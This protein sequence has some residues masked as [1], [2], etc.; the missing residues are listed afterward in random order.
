M[1]SNLRSWSKPLSKSETKKEY[2]KVKEGN[3]GTQASYQLSPDMGEY[4]IDQKIIE[5]KDGNDFVANYKLNDSYKLI[6]SENIK[7]SIKSNKEY[8]NPDVIFTKKIG[9]KS[10]NKFDIKKTMN[11]TENRAWF[12]ELY[13]ESV[14]G[15]KFKVILD[16]EEKKIIFDIEKLYNLDFQDYEFPKQIIYFGAPGTGKS[17]LLNKNAEPFKD[18]YRRITFHPNIMYSDLVGTFK[19]FPTQNSQTPITYEYIPGTLIKTLIDALTNPQ[20]PYLLII[21]EINRAN[22]S[23]AFGDMFQLLDRN[24][25][26]ESTYPIDV[27]EDLKLYL[28]KIKNNTKYSHE[29][30]LAIEETIKNGLKFPSN[31]YIWATMNSADQGV[32]PLDTAF[33]RRWNFKYIS[34]DSSYDEETF[35]TFGNISL[36]SN[37]E[38]TWN[39]MRQFINNKLSL[40]N[41]PEDKLL[42]PY[43]LS[44]NI[45]NSSTQTVTTAF[46]NKVLMYLFEDLGVHNRS[47]IFSTKLLRYSNIVDEFNKY[48]EK[49]F[50]GHEELSAS[51]FDSNNNFINNDNPEH[52]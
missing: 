14:A 12:I 44:K 22:V 4:L 19:P 46:K 26:G 39:D 29:A 32:M 33:K 37:R 52:S 1:N 7:N 18:K 23:A 3:G 20:T 38:V 51:I 27:N 35:K 50:L 30:S 28:D 25:D 24:E 36:G 8:D 21:E 34:I 45:L 43:F 49:I 47:K 5:Y 2:V 41:I 10:G 40:L 42:G 16:E 6:L 11:N 48:G 17:Y 31:L 13:D 9:K 15:D